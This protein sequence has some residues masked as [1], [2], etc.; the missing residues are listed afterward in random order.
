M[1]EHELDGAISKLSEA[2]Y[3]ND[4]LKFA[5]MYH[6]V[7]NETVKHYV[8]LYYVTHQDGQPPVFEY[9]NVLLPGSTWILS[10]TLEK[11]SILY[12]R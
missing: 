8:R 10:F 6:V 4:S 12:S 3:D 1:F 5:V 2:P 9:K 7:E 11:D